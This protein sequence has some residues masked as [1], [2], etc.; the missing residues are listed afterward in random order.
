MGFFHDLEGPCLSGPFEGPN[1][2]ALH[3]RALSVYANSKNAVA[4]LRSEEF[5]ST[6]LCNA[7]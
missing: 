5:V 7:W 3:E 6:I 4:G 1:A 2:I